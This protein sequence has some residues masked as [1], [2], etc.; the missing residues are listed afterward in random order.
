MWERLQNIDRRIIYTILLIVCFIP[1]ASPLGIPLQVNKTTQTVYDSIEAMD[2]ATDKVLFVMDYSVG[3]QADVHPQAVAV[4]KHLAK[5]GIPTVMVA[6]VIGG[7]M[8]AEQIIDELGDKWVYGTTVVDLGYM[9]G[10][11]TAVKGFCEDPKNSFVK[12][13][14]GNIVAD[15][16]I[17]QSIEKIQDFS[18][19]IDYQT[20]NPGYQEFLRQ[21][22]QGMRYAA[23][24]V[25]VS[26][27]NVIPYVNSGQLAG[28]L[29]GLRGAA[30]YEVLLKEPG[31]GAARM[32]AQSMGHLVI[33]LFI[34]V[35]NV[36]Y[37]FTKKKGTG[38]S[39]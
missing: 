5:K 36:A 32:D 20:G 26:V 38:R 22:P 3:G 4:A 27:P 9:A 2:P 35:G 23:G 15:L 19:I 18:Y 10:M 8:F 13:Q 6:F 28:L 21:L 30:E 31:E 25:T 29:Q 7:D 1:M 12:D 34:I 37:F 17:M 33:I 16:P 39:A 14:R 24:I 11:E